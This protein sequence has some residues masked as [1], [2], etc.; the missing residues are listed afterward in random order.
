MEQSALMDGVVIKG[1]QVASGSAKDSPYPD[2]SIPL[3]IP[4]FKALGLDLSECFPGTLNIAITPSR[5][6]ILH[7]SHKFEQVQWIA[8]FNAE[9]FSFADCQLWFKGKV[10]SGFIYYPHPETKTQ[11]FH[12]DEVLEVIC[13]PIANIAYGDKVRI[14]YLPRQ[15][16]IF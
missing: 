6:E 9:T 12:N 5:F 8:G 11:H 10:W 15:L 4:F 13:P 1:H 16:K 7:P 3:Q 2:G 14:E